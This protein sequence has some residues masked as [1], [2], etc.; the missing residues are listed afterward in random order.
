[1]D[2][3]LFR[4]VW[5]NSRGE[6]IFLLLVILASMP[7]YWISLEVP[8]QIVNDA[9][10]GHAF[11]NGQATALL[12]PLSIQMPDFLGGS[13]FELFRGFEVG[14]LGFL[15]GLSLWFLVLV[16]IN[17]AFKYF[18][19]IRK[20]I[21][22][23][24]ML[25]RMRFD[26]FALLMRFRPEDVTMVKPAEVASMIKDEVE[27]IGGFIGDAF[28]QPA[29]LMSQAATALLFIIVQSFWMGLAAFLIVLVQAIII[30]ILRREQLRLGRERQ[31]ASRRLAGRIGEVVE[32][33]LAVHTQGASRYIEAEIGD[34]LGHLYTI[35]ADLFRRK[36]AVKFLNNLLAQVTPFIFYAVGG[37]FA[38]Q[39]SL[40]IGQLV[41]VIA[42]YRDL[43][44]PIKELIDWDQ[45]RQDVTI[46]YQQVAVQFSPPLLLPTFSDSEPAKVPPPE[47]PIEISSLVV[48]DSRGSA[49]LSR[50]SLTIDRPA[51]IGIV[52]E[53]S[54]ARDVLA[55][56]LGRQMLTYQGHVRIGG[57]ELSAFSDR[58]LSRF[59]SYLGAD[60]ALHPVSMRDNLLMA[61]RR[62]APDLGKD[63]SDMRERRRRMEA[64]R[65]GNPLVSAHADWIDYEA[66][67][68]DGP[69]QID[70]ALLRVLTVAGA[71]QEVYRI[72]VLGQV[73]PERWP[74]APERFV[75]ARHL[76][77]QRLADGK[78]SNLV[79][80]FD[81]DRYNMS[82]PVGENLLFGVATGKRL[83]AEGLA[84]DPYM[85]SIIEAEAL[86]EP[87]IDIGLRL[88]EMAVE[89]FVGL[90]PNHPV[91][92]RY[93][94]IQPSDLDRFK[95]IVD[96]VK[97]R[98]SAAGLSH[99]ARTKLLAAGLAYIEPRHRLGRVDAAFTERVLRARRSFRMHLPI[100]YAGDVEFYEPDSYM[101]AAPIR[102]NILFGRIGYGLAN[103]QPRVY[104]VAR[105][106]LRELDLDRIINAIGLD[107]EVGKSGRLLQPT[108]RTQVA[109]ARSLVAYPD[110][111]IFESAF[112]GLPASETKALIGRLREE[113]A[114][115]TLIVT[116]I[117][118]AEA[119]GF[120]RIIRFDGP[121]MVADPVPEVALAS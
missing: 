20:G 26:L 23:E 30:P 85:R 44:P 103:A 73:D 80:P 19:N 66:M 104:A 100:H 84:A 79:E 61:V 107:F 119:E 111:A 63:G 38:L 91:F 55:R 15:I 14:Q 115:R 74:G 52:G 118:E 28:I 87:L 92:E 25:R 31:I 70:E 102:D 8:K 69:E 48:A 53:P 12:L 35:R 29:F 65:S 43:P 82:A 108:L 81:P 62:R 13:R 33:A 59:L 24:R 36:F 54:S 34:R 94:V 50:L 40:N 39:G 77:R 101:A 22:G 2:S 78:L 5:R 89:T 6:Q 86:I 45:Q 17:G 11:R 98:G 42:A 4:Y 68:I 113:L 49:L 105:E 60:Q 9:I 95:E 112:S 64:R 109:V 90:S 71:Q 106:V 21:L 72:G 121:N 116:V 47:A 1:M 57:T 83:K 96:S 88:A 32:T 120:D 37:Y 18:I 97:A 51:H 114:Q 99:S 16:L 93:S 58:D 76:I 46:K 75:E 7:F 110:I 41:A 3:S 10:Q 56:V 67:R 27:P 117:E